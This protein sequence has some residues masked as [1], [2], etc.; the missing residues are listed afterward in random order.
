[1]IQ[2]I[3]QVNTSEESSAHSSSPPVEAEALAH[4]VLLLHMIT[5]TQV[6]LTVLLLGVDALDLECSGCI[7]SR[8]SRELSKSKQRLCRDP[9]LEPP[10]SSEHRKET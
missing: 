4:H 5:G 7:R 2:Y 3:G 10:H 8:S 1:M 9:L 6:S